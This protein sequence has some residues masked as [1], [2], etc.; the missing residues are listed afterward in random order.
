MKARA[1][2]AKIL[3]VLG[4]I[5]LIIYAMGCH[6]LLTAPLGEAFAVSLFVIG[7]GVLLVVVGKKLNKKASSQTQETSPQIMDSSK[8]DVIFKEDQV[9][10]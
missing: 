7:I 5:I 1:I 6:T 9:S 3:Q 2:I 4:W 8:E 10:L